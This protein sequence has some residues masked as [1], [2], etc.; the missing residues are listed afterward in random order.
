[1]SNYQTPELWNRQNTVLQKCSMCYN[2]GHL[3][4]LSWSLI[5]RPLYCTPITN[6]EMPCACNFRVQLAVYRYPLKLWLTGCFT[7]NS[8][9]LSCICSRGLLNLQQSDVKLNCYIGDYGMLVC[10][11]LE[12]AGGV[13]LGR[14]CKVPLVYNIP[15][16]LLNKIVQEGKER[17]KSQ[18]VHKSDWCLWL[19]FS[20]LWSFTLTLISEAH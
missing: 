12:W 5:L 14:G 6:Y 18:C 20:V 11:V 7:A 2:Y 13:F 19:M 3:V 10:Y 4:F 1:M 17:T 15:P 9:F 16:T 8:R